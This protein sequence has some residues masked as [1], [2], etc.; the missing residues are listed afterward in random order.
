L[1]RLERTNSLTKQKQDELKKLTSGQSAINLSNNL[2]RILT[3]GA[4]EKGNFKVNEELDK[5]FKKA[6][7]ADSH[8]LFDLLHGL[9]IRFEVDGKNVD[10]TSIV[11]DIHTANPSFVH[12]LKEAGI[13]NDGKPV[14]EEQLNKLVKTINDEDNVEFRH[15]LKGKNALRSKRDYSKAE[16]DNLVESIR[17]YVDQQHSLN[18]MSIQT[19]IRL[20]S[21]MDQTYQYL[22]STNKALSDT[23]RTIARNV[24]GG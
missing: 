8:D 23:L 10:F 1:V 7:S 17:L 15:Y 19:L 3:L 20:E 22:M 18:D 11:K 13:Q 24:R 9:G 14:S 6:F 12:F 5:Q 2:R 21:E 16:K 4:D